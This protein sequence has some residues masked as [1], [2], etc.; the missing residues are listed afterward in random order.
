ML[1]QALSAELEEEDEVVVLI[2]QAGAVAMVPDVRQAG[3][4]DAGGV[5]LDERE[6]DRELL[7]DERCRLAAGQ[8]APDDVS[9]HGHSIV[10]RQV[11]GR[12]AER[13]RPRFDALPSS[14][15]ALWST[16]VVLPRSNKASGTCPASAGVVSAGTRERNIARMSY[17]TQAT[18]GRRPVFVASLRRPTLR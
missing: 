8:G 7:A 9:P 10:R 16:H 12:E 18:F 4:A 11:G 5:A 14:R 1:E 2:A 3:D 13:S 15:L 17:S 6:V